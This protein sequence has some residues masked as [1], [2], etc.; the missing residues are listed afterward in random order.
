MTKKEEER[1]IDGTLKRSDS[2]R[3]IQ[4]PGERRMKLLE[5]EEMRSEKERELEE[6]RRAQKIFENNIHV[7]QPRCAENLSV[8]KD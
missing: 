8:L 7:K 1:N 4:K 2:T 3:R 5:E 6:E